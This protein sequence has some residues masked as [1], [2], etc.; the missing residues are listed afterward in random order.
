[1]RTVGTLNAPPRSPSILPTNSCSLFSSICGMFGLLLQLRSRFDNAGLSALLAAITLQFRQFIPCDP[2]HGQATRLSELY[3]T[4][5][6]QGCVHRSED[7]NPSKKPC[8]SCS[9]PSRRGRMHVESVLEKALCV[10]TSR[11]S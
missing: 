1:M 8:A 7:I 5:R 4:G 6:E 10:A 3:L 9:A 11:S 2:D